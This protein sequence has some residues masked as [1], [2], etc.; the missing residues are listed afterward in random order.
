MDF[1]RCFWFLVDFN[2]FRSVWVCLAGFEMFFLFFL[3][4]WLVLG[5]F[6]VGGFLVCFFVFFKI[7]LSGF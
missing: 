2:R 4:F 7:G 5:W 3:V 1:S 6:V